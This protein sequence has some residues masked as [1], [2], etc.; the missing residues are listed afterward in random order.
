MVADESGM[1]RHP[2]GCSNKTVR[3]ER[4]EPRDR[5]Q[6]NTV[7]TT[8]DADAAEHGN[9][10]SKG[11]VSGA[12]RTESCSSGS[13]DDLQSHAPFAPSIAR[14]SEEFPRFGCVKRFVETYPHDCLPR[15]VGMSE[16]QW[17]S[18][19]PGRRVSNNKLPTPMECLEYK[20]IGPE[21]WTPY[22]LYVH[23]PVGMTKE[24]VLS[25]FHFSK[26]TS[27]ESFSP[28][29]GY[30]L[31]SNYDDM[32]SAYAINTHQRN[33]FPY[34][35]PA[36]RIIHVEESKNLSDASKL[37][38]PFSVMLRGLR[39]GTRADDLYHLFAA[40]KPTKCQLLRSKLTGEIVATLF[41]KSWKC[42]MRA[43]D[44]SAA[45]EVDFVLVE[46]SNVPGSTFD[47]DESWMLVGP[48]FPP[49][50]D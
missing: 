49:S 23:F 26:P 48:V 16:I 21:F 8:N 41:V 39:K 6:R 17:S 9:A 34:P 19:K 32:R 14:Q 27:F 12:E 29:R 5:Y 46:L 28:G 33:K 30:L 20:G 37:S 38:A 35:L 36:S 44:L 50:N 43:L 47:L 31:F 4:S 1:G 25:L 24:Q 13:N 40:V 18:T 22:E 7:G 3:S 42:I 45:A 15:A 2:A 11:A 10:K